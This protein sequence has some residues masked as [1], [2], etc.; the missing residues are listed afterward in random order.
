MVLLRAQ[1]LRKEATEE[2]VSMS[3]NESASGK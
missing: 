3:G 2:V 1:K